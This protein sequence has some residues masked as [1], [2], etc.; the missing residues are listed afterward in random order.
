MKEQP[1]LDKQIDFNVQTIQ[2]GYLVTHDDITS[3]YEDRNELSHGI[4]EHL[5][6]FLQQAETE[7]WEVA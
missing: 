6:I 5:D 1:S 3:Y 7:P 4:R 2:N